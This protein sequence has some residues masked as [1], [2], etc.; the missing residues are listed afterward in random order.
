MLR[1]KSEGRRRRA[2]I[3]DGEVEID[4]EEVESMTSRIGEG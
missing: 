2:Q 1:T 3:D 4:D